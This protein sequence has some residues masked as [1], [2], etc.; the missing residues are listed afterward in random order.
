MRPLGGWGGS[1]A[2]LTLL[3]PCSLD[4]EKLADWKDF[5]LVKSRRN[6]TMVS[7]PDARPWA[8]REGPLGCCPTLPTPLP[9][10]WKDSSFRER[11]GSSHLSFLLL[12]KVRR[13]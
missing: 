12:K 1:W 13:L 2:H 4:R 8:G 9:A 11:A 3:L 5:L 7:Y 6:V 10:V